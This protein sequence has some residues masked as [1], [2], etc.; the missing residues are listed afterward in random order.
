MK[1]LKGIEL[2]FDMI[3]KYIISISLVQFPFLGLPV[4]KQIYTAI[5]KKVLSTIE[6][7][8][9]LYIQFKLIDIDIKKKEKE[10]SESVNKLKKGEISDET[11]KKK[12]LNEVKTKLSD[13]INFKH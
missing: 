12:L 1:N 13:L 5:I 8:G 9:K 2:T 3:E 4:I 6:D 7:E 10:F 11:E